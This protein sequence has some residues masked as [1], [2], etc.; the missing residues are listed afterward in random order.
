MGVNLRMED[1]NRGTLNDKVT[2]RVGPSEIILSSN[3]ENMFGK[4]AP[5]TSG[6]IGSCRSSHRSMA[7][8]S[9]K[10]SSKYSVPTEEFKFEN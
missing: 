1:S 5:K 2:D 3:R 9:D 8:L 7:G 10:A 6:R 4:K